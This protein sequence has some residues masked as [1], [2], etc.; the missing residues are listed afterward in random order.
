MQICR[1]KKKVDNNE[2][3]KSELIDNYKQKKINSLYDSIFK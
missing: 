2:I 3:N 1:K